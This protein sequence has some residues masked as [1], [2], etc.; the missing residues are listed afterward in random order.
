MVHI[1]GKPVRSGK[2]SDGTQAKAHCRKALAWTSLL[3]RQLS[4][5]SQLKTL[6]FRDPV[7]TDQ[8]SYLGAGQM[9]E[10]LRVGLLLS[11]KASDLWHLDWKTK[12]LR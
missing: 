1:W 3:P 9:L 12:G 4:S 6:F 10:A 8:V 11:R 2:S 7:S 5:A